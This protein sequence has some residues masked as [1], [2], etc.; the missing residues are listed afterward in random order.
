[1]QRALPSVHRDGYVVPIEVDE[2]ALK[3][4]VAMLG[5]EDEARKAVARDQIYHLLE[6]L[7]TAHARTAYAGTT[8]DDKRALDRLLKFA[9][10][11]RMTAGLRASLDVL[12]P[13]RTSN[14]VLHRRI[15]QRLFAFRIEKAIRDLHE[16]ESTIFGIGRELSAAIAAVRVAIKSEDGRGRPQKSPDL[17][18][19]GRLHGV[20][21]EFTGR[22]TSRQSAF[23]RE[24]D[25][26]GD[27]VHAAG[28]LIDPEFDGHYVARQAHDARK[29][30]VK[31][32]VKVK[33][34]AKKKTRAKVNPKAKAKAK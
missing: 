23:G 5:I 31:A 24:K 16:A 7:Q 8:R 25:P 28:R 6:D 4:V 18:F 14:P 32:N 30:P 22:G 29:P 3:P 1:M 15:Q 12:E 21:V 9:D 17:S 34:K 13:L 20:W 11:E 19:A 27:F 26:F 2:E 10:P 33:A